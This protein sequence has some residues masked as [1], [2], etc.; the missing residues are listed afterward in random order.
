MITDNVS[1]TYRN[2]SGMGIPQ[3]QFNWVQIGNANSQTD[4]YNNGVI[5]E[6]G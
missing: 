1:V 6:P 2:G 5:D 4:L 3:V